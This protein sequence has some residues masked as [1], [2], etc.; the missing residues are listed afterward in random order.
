[1]VRLPVGPATAKAADLRLYR[2]TSSRRNSHSR[3]SMVKPSAESGSALK[4]SPA[5]VLPTRTASH[6]Q[7]ATPI[8]LSGLVGYSGRLDTYVRHL[9][10][11]ERG[12]HHQ[13]D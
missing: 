3:I 5:S 1:M 11:A 2:A 10:G 9:F 13:R 8:T 6:S 4:S 12:P 7:V